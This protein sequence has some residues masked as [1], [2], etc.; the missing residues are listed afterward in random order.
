MVKENR[1]RVDSAGKMCLEYQ[2]LEEFLIDRF[3]LTEED[4]DGNDM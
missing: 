1:W 3:E 4:L 2:Y